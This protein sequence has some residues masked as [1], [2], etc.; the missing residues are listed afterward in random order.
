MPKI[1]VKHTSIVI[2]NYDQGD[3]SQLERTFSVYDSLYH[4]RFIKGIEII[5]EEHKVIIPRG[6]DVFWVEKLFNDFADMNTKHD[7]MDTID[8]IMIKYLP[9]DDRQREAL[10]FMLGM[11]NYKNN[12]YKK[13]LI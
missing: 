7:P 9:R 11:E 1:E 13:V 5:P 6:V 3:N 10:K 2:N 12:K 4:T 8:P